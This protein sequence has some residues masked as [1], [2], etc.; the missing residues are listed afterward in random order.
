[1]IL[2]RGAGTQDAG[3]DHLDNDSPLVPCDQLHFFSVCPLLFTIIVVLL[4]PRCIFFVCGRT[5]SGWI[6][7]VFPGELP[8]T[9]PFHP[10]AFDGLGKSRMAL[11]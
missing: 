5:G 4:V 10:D 6:R 11:T 1:M 8:D 7:P 2:Y 9:G 3:T